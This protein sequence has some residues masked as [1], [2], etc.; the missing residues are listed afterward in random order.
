[1]SEVRIFQTSDF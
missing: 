1:M